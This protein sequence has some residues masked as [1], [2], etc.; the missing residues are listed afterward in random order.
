MAFRLPDKA[1]QWFTHI[2]K[3]N[4][5]EL[6]FDSYY[7]CLIT[8]LKKGKKEPYTNSDTTEIVQQFPGE[9]KQHRH[10]IIA[11]F[12]HTELTSLGISLKER[13]ALNKELATLIDPASATKL[14]DDGMKLLNRYAYGGYLQLVQHFP[15]PPRTLDGFLVGFYKFINSENLQQ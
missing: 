15:E 7:F 6:E 11:L 10:L 8:G 2:P 14:S 1:R 3:K 12:L 9:Y 5:F 13:N 4:G